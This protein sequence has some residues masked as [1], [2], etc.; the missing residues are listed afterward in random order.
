MAH[1]VGSFPG[2]GCSYEIT[3]TSPLGKPTYRGEDCE[4]VKAYLTSV[5]NSANEGIVKGPYEGTICQDGKCE[6][7]TRQTPQETLEIFNRVLKKPS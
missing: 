5:K 3:E 7:F 4:W 1:K 2:S 6:T